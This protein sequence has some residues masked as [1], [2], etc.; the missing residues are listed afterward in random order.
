[1]GYPSNECKNF[2]QRCFKCGK[3]FTLSGEDVSK[4]NNL[5]R[6]TCIIKGISLIVIIDISATHSFISLDC[7]KR[8]NLEVSPMIGSMVIELVRFQPCLYQLF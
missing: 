3:V 4:S 7:A 1:M 8:L 6:G 2:D 5:I